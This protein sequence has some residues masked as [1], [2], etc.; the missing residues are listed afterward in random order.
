MTRT[1]DE[2]KAELSSLHLQLH[3]TYVE[4]A[5]TVVL[6]RLQ[7]KYPQHANWFEKR[8]EP[9]AVAAFTMSLSMHPI[10]GAIMMQMEVDFVDMFRKMAT[11]HLHEFTRIAWESALTPAQATL[12]DLLHLYAYQYVVEVGKQ[13]LVD[14]M[15]GADAPPCKLATL[16]LHMVWAAHELKPDYEIEEERL[17][18]LAQVLTD[19]IQAIHEHM[20]GNDDMRDNT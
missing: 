1:E 9:L 5:E 18:Q 11:D 14:L 7:E 13:I 16:N 6:P 17:D 8:L 2:I 4:L 12:G 10:Q 20:L 19:S 15:N 3:K